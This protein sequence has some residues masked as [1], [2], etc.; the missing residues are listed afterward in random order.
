[1]FYFLFLEYIIK[2]GRREIIDYLKSLGGSPFL[3]RESWDSSKFNLS[4][5]FDVEPALSIHIL[6]RYQF[7]VDYGKKY[8]T[9]TSFEFNG[10]YD[11]SSNLRYDHYKEVLMDIFNVPLLNSTFRNDF[12]AHID[13]SLEGLEK[14]DK[15]VKNLVEN[16]VEH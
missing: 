12:E 10:G 11:N 14:M 8:F 5:I 9:P 4:R 3:N 13:K 2:T 16:I 6:L 7:Y 15:V 1:M